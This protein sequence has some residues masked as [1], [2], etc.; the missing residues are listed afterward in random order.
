MGAGWVVSVAL[1]L[2]K[3]RIDVIA[4]VGLVEGRAVRI[5]LLRDEGSHV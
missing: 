1:L 3:E 5:D 2:D 4:R